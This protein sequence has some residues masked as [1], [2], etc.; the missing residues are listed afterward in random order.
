[1]LR[2]NVTALELNNLV[3]KSK[4]RGDCTGH[5]R[6]YYHLTI[7]SCMYDYM[8]CSTVVLWPIQ[9]K[10]KCYGQTLRANVTGLGWITIELYTIVCT[11]ICTIVPLYYQLFKLKENLTCQCYGSCV[12]SFD[13]KKHEKEDIVLNMDGNITIELYTIVCTIVPLYYE[14]FK[15]QENVT[16]ERYG[17]FWITIELYTIVCTIICTT[18]PLHYELFQLKEN[19]TGERYGSW[20]KSFGRKNSRKEDIVLDMVGDITSATYGALT[21]HCTVRLPPSSL[22]T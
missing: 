8:Y 5:Y 14:L 18:V 6:Q 10:R 3:E 11:I 22:V 9:I 20:V 17:S 21:K 2:A 1:M 7:H 13:R 12:K 19:V 15:L 16:G 4:N